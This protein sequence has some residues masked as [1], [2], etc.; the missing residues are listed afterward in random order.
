MSAGTVLTSLTAPALAS[1]AKV[2]IL[3]SVAASALASFAGIPVVP[4]SFAGR[5]LRVSALAAVSIRGAS[6]AAI[7]LACV[8]GSSLR[9]LRWTAALRRLGAVIR[10]SF[11]RL[12]GLNLW[13]RFLFRRLRLLFLKRFLK[14]LRH[15]FFR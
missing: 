8:Y 11:H 6:S 15:R 14:C 1:F 5:S 7:L 13:R 9:L 2:S 3:V 12:L 4:S 10:L